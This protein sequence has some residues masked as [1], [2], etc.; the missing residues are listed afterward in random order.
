[1]H[2]KVGEPSCQVHYC[3]R[4]SYVQPKPDRDPDY[5][6]SY[7][8]LIHKD[9]NSD[10]QHP[11]ESWA[12]FHNPNAKHTDPRGWLTSQS[13]QNW[14]A[15]GTVRD[16]ASKTNKEGQAWQC[17]TLFPALGGWKW[18]WAKTG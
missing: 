6:I 13:S 17:M 8:Y 12:C 1:M 9:L 3:G 5:M 7:A 15:L 10:S 16:L 11:C 14:Q 2:I 18:E 4:G